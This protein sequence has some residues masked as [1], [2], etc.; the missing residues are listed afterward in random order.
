MLERW[1]DK[2]E[3][4]AFTRTVAGIQTMSNYE[5]ASLIARLDEELV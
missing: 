3:E 5:L 2:E 1:F 4:R